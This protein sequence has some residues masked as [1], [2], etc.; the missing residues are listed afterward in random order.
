[1][2]SI[3]QRLGEAVEKLTDAGKFKTY[4]EASKDCASVEAQLNCAERLL[5]APVKESKPPAKKNNGAGDNGTLLTESARTI[6]EKVD[7]FAKA[8]GIMYKGLGIS[9]ADQRRLKG[10]PP[11]GESLTPSQLR[12]FRF[13]RSINLSES[14]AL[15]G[16]KRVA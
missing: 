4:R 16:A 8:D 2:K 11:A 10:L 15:K 9:E 1:M 3:Y 5:G 14:D 12:E 13:L 7:P 6:S